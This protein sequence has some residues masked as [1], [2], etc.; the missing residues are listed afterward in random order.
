LR[1]LPPLAIAGRRKARSKSLA[2]DDGSR[3]STVPLRLVSGAVA[4]SDPCM[5]RCAAARSS[6]ECLSQ[7]ATGDDAYRAGAEVHDELAVAL[8][9]TALELVWSEHETALP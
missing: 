6:F 9:E 3:S 8:P 1:S 2:A 4:D 5:A 7:L